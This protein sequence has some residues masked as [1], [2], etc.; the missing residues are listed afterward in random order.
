MATH[1]KKEREKK[2]Y[3]Q[4][5]ISDGEESYI[6]NLSTVVGEADA[7]DKTCTMNEHHK[8]KFDDFRIPV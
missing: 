4:H 1:K 7:K 6:R 2:Q 3:Q 8:S 5:G